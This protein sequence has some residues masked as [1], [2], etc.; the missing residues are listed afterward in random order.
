[1]QP[2]QLPEHKTTLMNMAIND[3]ER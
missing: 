3:A 1:M 2:S